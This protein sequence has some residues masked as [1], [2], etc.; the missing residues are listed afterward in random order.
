ASRR[1]TPRG[2]TRS[3]GGS[4]RT[5]ATRP[6]SA[7]SRSSGSARTAAGSRR[8]P[9][10]DARDVAARAGPGASGRGELELAA[11][12]AGRVLRRVHVHVRAAGLDRVLQLVGDGGDAAHA[13]TARGAERDD[14]VA[15]LPGLAQVDVRGQ[16]RSAQAGDRQ[17]P[18]QPPAGEIAGEGAL[19]VGRGD[20]LL[21][22][23]LLGVERGVRGVTLRQRHAGTRARDHRDAEADRQ[24]SLPHSLPP[25]VARPDR[26][27][28]GRRLSRPRSGD[29]S[30]PVSRDQGQ[31]LHIPC[32]PPA[33]PMELAAGGPEQASPPSGRVSPG[34]LPGA[35]ATPTPRVRSTSA[36]AIETN[37]APHGSSRSTAISPATRSI[38]PTLITPSAKSAAMRA[39]QQA[40]HHAPWPRPMRSAP[41]APGR[42]PPIRKV[43]GALQRARQRHLAG[44]TW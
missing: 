30:G 26:Y 31:L 41:R 42:Q 4:W 28:P 15:R 13:A 32:E 21:R 36:M 24:D 23:L 17:L 2:S 38:H 9:R 16:G 44:V 10:A 18:T 29:A 8:A 12:L 3:G 5:S 33:I 1:W 35:A 27:G 43:N 40:T 25:L 22:D 39:Q 14:D 20:G 34:T 11:D 37:R 6:A 7:T 19:P